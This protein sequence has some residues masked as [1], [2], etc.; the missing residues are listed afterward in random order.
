MRYDRAAGE[1]VETGL[2]NPKIKRPAASGPLSVPGM[3]VPWRR[4]TPQ[5]GESVRWVCVDGRWVSIALGQGAEAGRT[6]VTSCEGRRELVDD[7][8]SALKL[9]K[10]WRV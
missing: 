5:P 9:A 3:Y 7:N 1:T 8:E 6:V 2:S 4:G 10:S